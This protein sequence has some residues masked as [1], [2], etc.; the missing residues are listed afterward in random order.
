MIKQVK[1]MPVK[2]LRGERRGEASEGI[3]ITV[4]CGPP[5]LSRASSDDTKTAARRQPLSKAASVV[6][7]SLRHH[8]GANSTA[9]QGITFCIT[10][11]TLPGPPSSDSTIAMAW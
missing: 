8:R 6:S 5:F 2:S 3:N 11:S 1:V 7:L 4:G 9:V 10:D